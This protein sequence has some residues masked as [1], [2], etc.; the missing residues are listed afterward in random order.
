MAKQYERPTIKQTPDKHHES[1]ERHPAYA[2]IGASR[3]SATPGQF[4]FG[5]DFRH[6]HFVRI[7]VLPASR[8]RSLAHDWIHPTS[9]TPLI[10][11]NLSESQWAA[12]VSTLNSGDG[13]PCTLDRVIDRGDVPGIEGTPDRTRQFSAEARETLQ[14]TAQALD[15][16]QQRIQG[17]KM[18]AGVRDALLADIHKAKMNLGGNLDFVAKSFSQHVERTVDQAR[19]EIA[20]HVQAAISRAGLKA[21]GAS[22]DAV[23]Q[24]A[25]G[26]P[27]PEGGQS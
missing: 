26:E 23:L 25:P 20:A 21:L 14:R 11:V 12:F 18:A 3:V 22:E 24:L 6:G 16:M 13:V 15:D 2:V 4:L 5:S 7:R 27:E 17:A 8:H 1:E 19:A 9:L 10:E